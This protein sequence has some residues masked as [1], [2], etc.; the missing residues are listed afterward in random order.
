MNWFASTI[1]PKFEREMLI[2]LHAMSKHFCTLYLIWIFWLQVSN[3][4]PNN[5]SKW[6]TTN[7]S[8]SFNEMMYY[9]KTYD[10]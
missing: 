7:V 1:L 10:K 3:L 6:F 9:E 8:F 4:Q 5:A 2:F